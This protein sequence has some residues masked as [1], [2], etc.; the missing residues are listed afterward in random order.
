MKEQLNSKT[1][2]QSIKPYSYRELAALYE[3]S[4]R[5]L[6]RW[7]MPFMIEIGEKKGRYFNLR[8]IRLIFEKLG[9][10]PGIVDS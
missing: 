1:N 4:D 8:Q 9:M 10:P 6:K 2:Q 3:I 5:C 7:L